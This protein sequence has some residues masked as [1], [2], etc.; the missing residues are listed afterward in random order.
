MSKA[1]TRR[2]EGGALAGRS[3]S[4]NHVRLLLTRCSQPAISGGG[5]GGALA[6]LSLSVL[7]YKPQRLSGCQGKRLSQ[8]KYLNERDIFEKKQITFSTYLEIPALVRLQNP[9]T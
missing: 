3:H 9:F 4:P 2:G 6:R 8:S 7:K 5:V 1:C